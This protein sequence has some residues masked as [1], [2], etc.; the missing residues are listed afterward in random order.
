MNTITGLDHQREFAA[1]WAD[2]RHTRFE[3]PPADIN[4]LL[5]DR[6]ATGSPLSFTRDMLGEVEVGK[7]WQPD[8]YIPG[9]VRAGSACT[10]GRWQEADGTESFARS[11]WQRLWL[12]PGDY[13]LVLE[14]TH[15]DHQAQKATFIGTAELSGQDGEPLHGD[16]R[17]ALFHVQHWVGGE[18]RGAAGPPRP[19][20]PVPRSAGCPPASR[21]APGCRNTSRSTSATTCASRSS[22]EQGS[23]TMSLR[24]LALSRG[25]WARCCPSR[26]AAPAQP[27]GA[28]C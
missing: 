15:L 18:P 19:A 1:A 7:A 11:S 20:S 16:P 6:Y 23:M 22:A 27:G 21:Q 2:A 9:V 12:Q 24:E 10:W 17:Q 3:L 5:G 14:Q 25:W 4:E 28:G 13:G 8:R 26:P